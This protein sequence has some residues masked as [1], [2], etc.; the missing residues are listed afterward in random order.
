[1]AVC[2]VGESWVVPGL[3]MGIVSLAMGFTIL[4]ADS[5]G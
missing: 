4:W 5:G 2:H 3:S 1:M